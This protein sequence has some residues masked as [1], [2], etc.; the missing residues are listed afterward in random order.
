MFEWESPLQVCVAYSTPPPNAVS[1]KNQGRTRQSGSYFG[2][3]PWLL[4]AAERFPMANGFL[5]LSG[6]FETQ[7]ALVRLA[8]QPTLFR[9]GPS[10]PVRGM[11]YLPGLSVPTSFGTL[12]CSAE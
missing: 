12:G 1:R 11:A 9:L 6:R 4:V 8:F 2:T 7:L 10:D 3:I 5:P